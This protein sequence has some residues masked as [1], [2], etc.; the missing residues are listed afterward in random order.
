MSIERWSNNILEVKKFSCFTVILTQETPDKMK[1]NEEAAKLKARAVRIHITRQELLKRDSSC[2]CT[3]RE[4]L[5]DKLRK[6]RYECSLC[7]RLLTG[8]VITYHLC[9]SHKMP[10]CT[11][12]PCGNFLTDDIRVVK[13]FSG[14]VPRCVGMGQGSSYCGLRTTKESNS[15]HKA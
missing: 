6:F 5:D 11:S 4:A 2:P 3:E 12:E 13:P 7:V 8:Q 10:F 14:K 1:G 15:K 9:E